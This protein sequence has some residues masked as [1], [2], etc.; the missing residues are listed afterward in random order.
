MAFSMV[1][2]HDVARP[3]VCVT[4]D[5]REAIQRGRRPSLER[6]GPVLS[7]VVQTDACLHYQAM[8]G[9]LLV[10]YTS[11]IVFD[12]KLLQACFGQTW[13]DG[14]KGLRSKRSGS[15]GFA[16]WP[17]AYHDDDCQ[18]H[19]D[20]YEQCYDDVHIMTR[21][22]RGGEMLHE[23]SPICPS[24]DKGVCCIEVS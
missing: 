13:I 9:I 22:S 11:S 19:G 21:L 3:G 23:D 14:C 5:R 17:R 12:E 16:V 10:Q 6:T 18:K 7:D 15:P 4:G 20:S 1:Q 8:T 2:A 24:Y